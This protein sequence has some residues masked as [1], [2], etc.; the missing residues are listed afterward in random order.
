M[1]KLLIGL[2]LL[3]LSIP[4][5]SQEKY[6][7]SGTIKDAENGEDL[8]GAAVTIQGT[9]TGTVTNFY[10]FYSLSMEQGEY[11]L[12]ISYLGYQTITR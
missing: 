11:T 7:V 3:F 10:G 12:N 4:S 9:S 6:T 1:Q 8:I 5:F 2:F